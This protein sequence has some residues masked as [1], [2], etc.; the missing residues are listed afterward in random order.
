MKLLLLSSLAL[1]SSTSIVNAQQNPL[2]RISCSWDSRNNR[3]NIVQRCDRRNDGRNWPYSCEDGR[4]VCC[5][6]S[7]INEPDM[8]EFGTCERVVGGPPAPVRPTRKPT[9]R[10]PDAPANSLQCIAPQERRI[11]REGHRSV[12]E[13]LSGVSLYLI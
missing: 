7:Y 1:V 9:N 3:N 12:C 2:N 5:T 11:R 8:K 4:Q 10:R 13:S 6:E